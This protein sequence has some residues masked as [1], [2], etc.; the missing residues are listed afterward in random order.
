VKRYLILEEV[1]S[2]EPHYRK[3][4]LWVNRDAP[5]PTLANVDSLRD[6]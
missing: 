5:Y 4:A 6:S 3:N 1:H 2:G